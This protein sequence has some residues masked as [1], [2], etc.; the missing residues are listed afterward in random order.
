MAIRDILKMG[1]PRLLRQAEPVQQFG[2]PEMDVLIAD[3]FET[4]RAVNG[5]GLAAPQIGV[6]LQ[7]VIF[8]FKKNQ[9]YPDAP[10]VPETVLINPTLTPLG[11]EQDEGWEGCLSVPG[12]RGV[13]PRWSRLRYE[14]VDEKGNRIDRTV[15]GFHA[16]VVQHECDH[17]IGVLYPMRIKDFTRFGFTEILFP[18]LD[19]NDDD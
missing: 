17:L 5:A 2:T 8:G 14:G 15:D 13:V 12:L 6:N 1:D 3:M 11:D 18:E 10:E 9:R 4:M 16:R 19:P 7:L